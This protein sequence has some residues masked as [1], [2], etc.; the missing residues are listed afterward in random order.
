M[1]LRFGGAGELGMVLSEEGG[2]VLDAACCLLGVV[3]VSSCEDMIACQR[4]RAK[5]AYTSL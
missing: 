5:T 4:A 2:A 1:S 3:V